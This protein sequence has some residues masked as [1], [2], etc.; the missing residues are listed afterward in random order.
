MLRKSRKMFITEYIII[1]YIISLLRDTL[2]MK[3]EN[4]TNSNKRKTIY[5]L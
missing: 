5:F 1:L 4:V 3:T 2:I